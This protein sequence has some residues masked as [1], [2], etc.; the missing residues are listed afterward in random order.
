MYPGRLRLIVA[1]AAAVGGV[2]MGGDANC[3]DTSARI[4]IHETFIYATEE[5]APGAARKNS[6]R[7]RGC[8]LRRIGVT[9]L[10]F[11]L[12]ALTRND[13]LPRSCMPHRPPRYES[14][15]LGPPESRLE[16]MQ[17]GT[18]PVAC[19]HRTT[20]ATLRP[21]PQANR[22]FNS[23][24]RGYVSWR[25]SRR[26]FGRRLAASEKGLQWPTRLD[27]SRR[28]RLARSVYAE[29]NAPLIA[30]IFGVWR[31][32][33]NKKGG[34]GVSASKIRKPLRG[35]ITVDGLLRNTGQ[36]I[37]FH[38][39]DDELGGVNI[40]LGPLSYRYRVYELR[41]HFG[42]TDDRGSEHSVS[43]FVFPAEVSFRPGTNSIQPIQ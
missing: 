15:L 30:M 18:P 29:R 3:G 4:L 13:R 1:A 24:E 34:R 5:A 27:W 8:V 2:G 38:L 35:V 12:R 19:Q 33:Q 37:V 17:H 11:G 31:Q 16:F 41:L 20:T 32:I 42:R 26:S 40:S 43:G 14:G 9:P 39:S 6:E 21:E 28:N 7:K 22:S 23:Q 10:R 25:S 36:G